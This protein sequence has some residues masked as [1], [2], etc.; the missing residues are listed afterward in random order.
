MNKYIE[1]FQVNDYVITVQLPKSYFKCNNRYYPLLCVQD[2]D[3][4]FKGRKKEV[5]FVGIESKDRANDFTPWQ[6]SIGSELNGGQADK[7]LTWL[8]EKLIPLLRDK[9]RVSN[10]NNDIGIAGASFGALVSLYALYTMPQKFGSY[11]LISP[12]LWYPQFVEFMQN[13]NAI[14][15]EVSVYWYVGLKEGIKHT[16]RIKKMVPHSLEGVKILEQSL[17]NNNSRFKFQTSKRG[18]HRHRFF[19][20]YFNKALK[21]IY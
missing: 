17:K 3:Y 1:K 16:L 8:T 11:I 9:Y 10:D 7:Y 13:H 14:N 6:A 21:Y 15:K 5:I 19:K 20:K 2:G 12:S 4:L 18:I